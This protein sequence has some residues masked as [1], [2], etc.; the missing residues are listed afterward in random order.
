M[1]L[2]IEPL[3]EKQNVELIQVAMMRRQLE[4]WGMNFGEMLS[5]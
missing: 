1:M 2:K 4:T 5:L 3:N